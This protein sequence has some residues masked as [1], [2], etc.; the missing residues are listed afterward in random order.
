ML[1]RSAEYTLE[2]HP[3]P[4]GSDAPSLLPAKANQKKR[5]RIHGNT[6]P[7]PAE[8]HRLRLETHNFRTSRNTHNIN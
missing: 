8:N 5:E 2:P 1:D 4:S 3:D 6:I 7:L